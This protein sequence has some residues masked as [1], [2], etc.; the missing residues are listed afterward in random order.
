MGKFELKS[1]FL[2]QNIEFKNEKERL[3]TYNS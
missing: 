3:N 1:P 2:K